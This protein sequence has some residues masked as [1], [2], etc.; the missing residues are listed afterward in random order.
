MSDKYAQPLCS[1]CGIRDIAKQ[2]AFM[3][4][5]IKVAGAVA[6]TLVGIIFTLIA[7]TRADM[8]ELHEKSENQCASLQREAMK[9][10]QEM[11]NNFLGVTTE[12]ANDSNDI[13]QVLNVISINQKRVLETLDIPYMEPEWV[14]KPE[15]KKI[16]QR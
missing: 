7:V 11:A 13:M 4:G 9:R 10:D 15:K 3:L 1:T 6:L 5:A 14:H 12:L 16:I 8:E 2:V